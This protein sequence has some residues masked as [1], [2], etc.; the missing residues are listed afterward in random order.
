MVREVEDFFAGKSEEWSFALC[1]APTESTESSE[2]IGTG[3]FVR[4]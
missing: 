2:S 3:D 1:A 4:M